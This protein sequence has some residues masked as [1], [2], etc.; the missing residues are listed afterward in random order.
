M[1]EYPL[2]ANDSALMQVEYANGALGVIH[3]TRWATGHANSLFLR[4]HGTKVSLR[5]D[6]DKSYNELEVCLGEDIHKAKWTTLKAPQTPSI[7]ERFITASD[8]NARRLPG[9]RRPFDASACPDLSPAQRPDVPRPQQVRTTADL[10]ER[11][12]A[13]RRKVVRGSWTAAISGGQTNAPAP[14]RSAAPESLR[15]PPAPSRRW[16]APRWTHCAR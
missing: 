16:T 5:L 14:S 7:Y 8:R 4:V 3:T 10:V 9:L 6:L 1:G 13:D 12:L 15:Q 2:D 11:N